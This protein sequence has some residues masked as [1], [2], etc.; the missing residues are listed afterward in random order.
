MAPKIFITGITGYIA[1]DAFYAI[2]KAHADYE[3]SA[4]IRTEEKAGKVRA[5]YPDVRVVIGGLD[6]SSI[7]EEESAKAD[8][9]LHAADASD[10]EGA[11]KA[12]EAGILKGHSAERPG[13]WLHTGGT[14][15]LTYFDPSKERFGEEP[16]REF[17]DWSGVKELATLPDDAFH[18]NVD[19]IVLEAGTK[20]ADVIKT[21]LFDELEGTV[22][23]SYLSILSTA[24][25]IGRGPVS[26]RGRQAYELAKTILQKG[27]APIIGEGR[28]HWDN[29]HVH[30]LSE[31]YLALVDAAVEQK[32]DSELWGEKGYFFV[33]NGRHV[34]GDLSRLI[35]Q[36]ASDA[37]YIPKEFEEQKLSKD[38]AWELADFQA[39]SWGLNSQGKAERARKVLGWQ[40]K[41]GSLEDE[42]PHII[43]QEKG[44]LQ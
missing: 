28:A 1:G 10:H 18:R 42:V 41:E 2:H 39:L 34:C 43:E 4:L 31:V 40:P 44:R 12:I 35:A 25:G 13:F 15:I 20:H 24:D 23:G 33:A 26:G 32:L 21:A 9:V 19:K 11:A 5:S 36:K 30:D 16:D 6:D 22:V 27:Y 3:Y 37:G 38:E 29:V 17:N 7:I 8:I 14:G